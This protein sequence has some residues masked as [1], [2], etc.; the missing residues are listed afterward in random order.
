VANVI[1]TGLCVS[2]WGYFLYQ[3][4]VDPLGGIN[5]LWPLFGIANQMLA[6][7]ALI[8]AA[9]VLLKMKR[10]KYV[11]VAAVPALFLVICTST[12]GLQKIFHSDPRIGFLALADK[13]QTALD[14]GKVLAPA[15]SLD[16]MSTLIFNNQLNTGLTAL[17][18]FVVF[19]ILLFGIR[20]GLQALRNPQETSRELPYQPLPADVLPT[21]V[22]KQAS[23]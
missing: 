3:G 15:K 10:Q 6:A 16:E 5:T 4:V 19:S 12:A 9:V 13:Y 20:T 8:L 22:L 17:F 7:I 11:W 18:L 21:D 1:A 23:S 2:A 14:S